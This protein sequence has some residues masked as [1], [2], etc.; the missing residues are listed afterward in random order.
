MPEGTY[1]LSRLHK[2]GLF[3]ETSS[4]INSILNSGSKLAYSYNWLTIDAVAFPDETGSVAFAYGK[5]AKYASEGEVPVI[6]PSARSEDKVLEK[7]MRKAVSPFIYIP[8]ENAVVHLKVWNDISEDTFRARFA[9]VVTSSEAGRLLDCSLTSIDDAADFLAKVQNLDLISKIT[10]TVVPPNPLHGRKW[11]QIKE[12]LERRNSSELH[13][14]EKAI[15]QQSLDS[16]LQKI[17]EDAP[18]DQPTDDS[19]ENL[20]VVDA[21]VLMAL[22]GYGKGKV[23]GTI[24][25]ESKTIATHD[26]E[27]SF[28]FD[29]DPDPMELY[30]A[31]TDILNDINRRRGLEH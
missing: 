27:I 15:P 13:L 26:T 12:E 20:D 19:Q 31:S 7:N 29:N 14:S 25:G 9:D 1:F 2:N 5:L 28:N 4:I 17:T 23:V 22:D 10:V 30:K 6:D 18:S 3:G 24:N 21:A 16:Q 8:E 11:K